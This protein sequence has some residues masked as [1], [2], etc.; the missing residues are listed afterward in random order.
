M[1]RSMSV[2]GLAE[3]LTVE[4]R[5][6][7]H[8]LR[9]HDERELGL[10]DWNRRAVEAIGP[11]IE[12]GLPLT[13][14]QMKIWRALARNTQRLVTANAHEDSRLHAPVLALVAS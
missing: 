10:L 5:S 11:R 12:A 2:A 1:G 8:E 3:E 4:M 14:T 13:A 7:A 9:T 6:L